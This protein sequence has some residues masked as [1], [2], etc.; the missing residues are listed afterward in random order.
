[1]HSFYVKNYSWF[2]LCEI[3]FL[4]WDRYIL[5]E[6]H[7][8]SSYIQWFCFGSSINFIR[9]HQMSQVRLGVQVLAT[10][11]LIQFPVNVP[12]KALEYCP[13]FW[14]PAIHVQEL[15]V[16]HGSYLLSGPTPICSGHL[17]SEPLGGGSV[18]FTAL[19]ESLHWLLQYCFVSLC[20]SN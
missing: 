20:L 2:L 18:S 14:S 17:E 8:Q 1:M 4:H 15:D 7:C 10:Q 6:L 3:R 13:N 16:I 12:G 19:P 11:L 5:S 9:L